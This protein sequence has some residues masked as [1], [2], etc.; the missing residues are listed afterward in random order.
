DATTIF[1]S[2]TVRNLGIILDPSL[3]FDAHIRSLSKTSFFHLQRIVKL[4][5]FIC[6]NDA[7]I[8]VHA[9]ITSRLDY[10]NSLF[11]GL[12][13][14]SI[15]RLQ[16]IQNSAARMLT[17]NKKSAHIT[18][19]LF[20]LHWLPVSS[21][22]KYKIILLT[23]KALNALSPPYLSDLLSSYVPS[24]SLRSSNSE[25]LWVPRF[26]LSSAGGRAF[27]VIAPILW[28]SLPIALRTITT[29]TEF[30]SRLKTHLFNL[31]YQ[32]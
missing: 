15:S 29:L 14:H 30:K 3:S 6:R 10:C 12:S 21:R 31:H 1:P 7:E 24:R 9:L 13:A 8:L 11:S 16:Y 28:N 32:S 19:I 2:A 4:R 5:P 20:D 22:I 17:S 25:L 18:P 23:Y 26:R 27:S